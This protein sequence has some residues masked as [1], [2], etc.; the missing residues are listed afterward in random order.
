MRLHRTLDK[1][2][3][4]K[5][6]SFFCNLMLL[7]PAQWLICDLR[8]ADLL[9][10]VHCLGL[11][12]DDQKAQDMPARCLILAHMCDGLRQFCVASVGV[13]TARPLPAPL[14]ETHAFQFSD[15]ITFS[16]PI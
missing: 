7:I 16:H 11:R 5:E 15:D 1:V 13:K 4:L 9:W 2:L 8:V 12:Q 14:L 6:M 3:L 10:P